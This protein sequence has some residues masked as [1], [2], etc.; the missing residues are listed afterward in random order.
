MHK[1]HPSYDLE[2]LIVESPDSI[3]IVVS[4]ADSYKQI[5]FTNV[6]HAV[7]LIGKSPYKLLMKE[8][9]LLL[10][11]ELETLE[12]FEIPYSTY[13]YLIQ[14]SYYG[15]KPIIETFLY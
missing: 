6:K 12:V 7:T 3:S 14:E 13:N 9:Q 10:Y 2:F 15:E 8:V 4:Y 1:V 5:K 11:A